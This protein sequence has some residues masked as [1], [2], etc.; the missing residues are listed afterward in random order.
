[1]LRS[2]NNQNKYSNS[3]KISRNFWFYTI[4]QLLMLILSLFASLMIINFVPYYQY[5]KYA[6]I[7]SGVNLISI[8]S[9]FGIPRALLR[10][11]PEL[12]ENKIISKYFL[13]GLILI[14]SISLIISSI[15]RFLFQIIYQNIE[16]IS[17]GLNIQIILIIINSLNTFTYYFIV[18]L[19]KMDFSFAGNA[20]KY[21]IWAFSI[22]SLIFLFNNYEYTNFLIGYLIG[23]SISLIFEF[24][25]LLYFFR[26]KRYDIDVFNF[27]TFK[28]ITKN[29]AF[30]SISGLS[31]SICGIFVFTYGIIFLGYFTNLYDISSFDFYST[32]CYGIFVMMTSLIGA[33]FPYLVNFY[34]DDYKKFKEITVSAFRI[35]TS[36]TLFIILLG[37]IFSVQ[38]L[39][40]LSSNRYVN[41]VSTFQILL[42]FILF[43]G[44][45]SQM[46]SVFFIAKKLKIFFLGNISIILSY[47]SFSM[48]FVNFLKSS[49]GI[50]LGLLI[51]NI[52]IFII[53]IILLKNKLDI[54][55]LNS[56]SIK[57]ILMI[58]LPIM[59]VY[60][61]IFIS[62][63]MK[64]DLIIN[65]N[66]ILIYIGVGI[67]LFLLI[68][69]L[70]IM[71]FDLLKLLFFKIKK[72]KQG[73]Q[74]DSKFR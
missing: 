74:N 54:L 25:Y 70:Y 5:G 51:S 34:C 13:T 48:I 43:F 67:S 3:E 69:S 22:F 10:Q 18:A 65:Y 73:N 26:K 53:L 45:N 9:A 42:V 52:V 62:D 24:I 1:M 23:N 31:S 4:D 6:L 60:F 59:A 16:N 63:I 8:F 66:N 72:P 32:I 71:D 44:L 61:I 68:Y 15:F 46:L 11:I 27:N 55:L 58:I 38:I 41:N 40:L 2:E 57:Q 29:I 30:P 21:L 37:N 7:M 17:I 12:K 50:A 49:L 19:K 64:Y 47:F 36:I 20:I 39:S 56:K 28:K 14:F 33:L 35:F